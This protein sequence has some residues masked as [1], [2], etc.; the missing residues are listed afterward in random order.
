MASQG[1]G[2]YA[3]AG[4]SME[5]QEGT[6]R[7]WDTRPPCS[8]DGPRDP[9]QGALGPWAGTSRSGARMQPRLLALLTPPLTLCL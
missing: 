6:Q 3:R 5:T 9:G 7:L 1:V 8:A 2:G 4:A